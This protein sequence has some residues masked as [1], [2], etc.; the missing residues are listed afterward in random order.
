MGG[1]GG[2]RGSE[3]RR[4]ELRGAG[5]S[6]GEAGGALGFEGHRRELRGAGGSW[7]EPEEPGVLRAIVGSYGELEGAG[8]EPEG[9]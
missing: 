5:G 9:S 7:G 8:G 2:A 6:W 1:I 3:G 4:R